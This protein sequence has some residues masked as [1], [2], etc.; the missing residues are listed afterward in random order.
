ML[1]WAGQDGLAC[2]MP[3]KWHT[4]VRALCSPCR[5]FITS[6]GFDMVIAVSGQLV[7]HPYCHLART[8]ADLL[9]CSEALVTTESFGNWSALWRQGLHVVL[10]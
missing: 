8:L 1:S 10:V 5:V 4:I 9:S 7:L 3:V 2:S 6:D